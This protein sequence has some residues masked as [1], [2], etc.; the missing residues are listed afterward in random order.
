MRDI[1]DPMADYTR[2]IRKSIGVPELHE[3]LQWETK[4]DRETA[5]NLLNVAISDIKSNTCKLTDSQLS[6]IYRL[7][8]ELSWP[9]HR[10]DATNVFLSRGKEAEDVWEKQVLQPS[11]KIVRD[12]LNGNKNYV[13]H[14]FY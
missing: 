11:L 3:Y 2:G 6:K 14:H 1:Y 13:H 4:V 7:R 10:V 5:E 8:K 9:I 12:F